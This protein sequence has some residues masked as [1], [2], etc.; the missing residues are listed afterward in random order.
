MSNLQSNT[1]TIDS[2][3]IKELTNMLRKNNEFKSL[4]AEPLIND[5]TFLNFII[6]RTLYDKAHETPPQR[7]KPWEL[8]LNSLIQHLNK[9]GAIY[10]KKI[11]SIYLDEY[12]AIKYSSQPKSLAN[13]LNG[14][15]KFQSELFAHILDINPL[16]PV[17]AECNKE[18]FH[19]VA[20]F[21]V[22]QFEKKFTFKEKT[23]EHFIT[24]IKLWPQI[25]NQALDC[26][27][28]AIYPTADISQ[29]KITSK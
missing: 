24:I 5:D 12:R 4:I 2:S 23:P 9:I 27:C 25:L 7:S 3:E 18:R 15:N 26:Y 10:H 20:A 22:Y 29:I 14:W 28:L 8:N 17:V 16:S 11:L 1:F 21:I 13:H 19:L 6:L